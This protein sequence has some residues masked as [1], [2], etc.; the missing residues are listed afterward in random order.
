MKRIIKDY[1]SFSKK[2]RTAVILLLIVSAGFIA[3]PYFFSIKGGVPAMDPA[4]QAFEEKNKKVDSPGELGDTKINTTLFYFD[5]NTISAEGWVRLGVRERTAATIVKYRSKGGK[6]RTAEDIRKIWGIPKQQADRLIPYVKLEASAENLFY[7][8]SFDKKA[9]VE[10]RPATGKMPSVVEINTATIEEWKALP[11]IGEVL[12]SRIV[13]YRERIGG[14][15]GIMQVKKVYGIS[16]SVFQELLPF[17][18]A[19]EA[20]LPK[21][22]LN[23]A[24]QNALQERAGIAAE[25]AKGIISYRRQYGNFKSVDDLKNI[26][27]ITDSIFTHIRRFVIV[28]P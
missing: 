10:N 13:H 6:F 3:L 2:E 20:V 22:D 5:P 16:D 9:P 23:T 19:D 8:K 28:K 7:K 15:W 25:T 21:L 27:F 17:L 26:V 12:A 11:G 14:F 4:L 18:R 1:F 24:T